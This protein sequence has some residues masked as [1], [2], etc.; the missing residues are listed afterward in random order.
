M[1]QL[2]SV[3]F[4]VDIYIHTHIT[5]CFSTIEANECSYGSPACMPSTEQTL[6]MNFLASNT[7]QEEK[8]NWQAQG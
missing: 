6:R 7:V 2:V 1:T 3:V 8:T 4:I 5:D